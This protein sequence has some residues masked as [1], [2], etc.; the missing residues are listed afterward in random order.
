MSEALIYLD[1]DSKLSLQ[2]Q[3]RQKLVDA[4]LHGVFPAGTRLPSSRKLAEQLGVARNTVVL[5]YEQLV[6][7]GYVESRQRSGIYVNDRVLEGRIGFSGKPSGNARLGDRWRNRIRSGAQP[8]AE[9]QWPADWQQHPYPFIDGYF[10]SSL[11][12]TAQWR[13]ASRL[14]LGARVIHEGTV[15]EGHADDPALVEEIRSKML[16]RR[17]IHAEANEILITLGEQNALYLLTQLLTAAGTCVAMEE[18]GNPRMRQLLKQAGAEIL[19]QPVDEFGMVVNS[20]LKSAQLIYVTPSHQVPTAVTMPNQRRRALLKQAEQH[21]QLIIED[22]FEHENNYLGKPHPAL[23]GMD[24]SDRV[25]YVSALPKVL[26]PGL[27]IGFIVAAP[28]L[29][30]EARKLRQMVIGR[31]SLINQRTAAFFLSLGHYDAF[32]ARL[33]KIM[34]ERW[35]ALRQALNHYH[36]GSEIEFPTQGGTALWV[37]SPEHVQVDHLVAEAAR[38]GILIEPDTHYYGGGRASRNHFRMGVTSIPAEHIREGVNQLE[39]LILELSAEHIEMLDPGDP[40]LQDGKQL[41]QLLPGA[42]IIYKTYYGAPCTIELRPDGRMV[43]RSGH[44]NEDC[45]TGR[46]WV[47]GDLYCRRWE[48]W[49]YGEEAA[50][51][52][53]LEGKHIRWWRPGGRLVDSAIIQV[54]ERHLDS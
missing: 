44:A 53:T 27:R 24:E 46:W 17:G 21:D 32:M 16:P 23:R 3:I 7:E 39:Q 4:I 35:D 36:R 29:I 14:A 25:I 5:A 47:D 9:F 52:V 49:S 37:E 43:G 50:Y 18:P 6:E 28:E 2:G 22:D 38:R 45:D 1:P 42:T 33:H 54:A 31:P 13:E 48:R 51:Q 40:Q 41:K 34:G 19:E 10:D 26:A 12:P 8:Q 30:R 15:T 20:R 11:Y